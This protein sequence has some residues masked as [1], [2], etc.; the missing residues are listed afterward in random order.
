[1]SPAGGAPRI[2]VTLMVAA[3]QSEPEIAARKISLYLDAVARHGAE[4]VALDARATRADREAAFASMDGLL[5]T[6]GADI[7]PARYGQ[8]VEGA[9]DV[10]PGRDSSRPRPGRRLRRAASRCWASA[11]ASR[12]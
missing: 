12:R 8:A 7:D 2:V 9:R 3:E 6:G 5:L 11:A 1:M 4:T 10:E